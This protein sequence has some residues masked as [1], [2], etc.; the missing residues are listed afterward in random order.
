MAGRD[1]LVSIVMP[2]HNGA[3]WLDEALA[4]VLAQTMGDFELVAVD[5]GSTD[6]TPGMLAAYAARD[7][8][9]RVLT[10]TSSQ[11]AGPARNSGLSAARGEYLL[12][13][14]ADDAFEPTL[15]ER[16][17]AAAQAAQADMV[18]FGADEL[19][20][21]RRRKNRF[22]FVEE[23]L[24][25]RDPFNRDDVPTRLFQ[26]CTPEAWSKL[27][28]RDFVEEQ[29]LR[30]QDL[31]NTNDMLFTMSAL[32]L[33]RRVTSVREVLVHHRVGRRGSIQS[34][35]GRSL[36]FLDALRA[37][38]ARL[39][40][41]GLL[42]QLQESFANLAVFHCLFNDKAPAPWPHVFAE[43]GVNQLASDAYWLEGDF[44]RVAGLI[45]GSWDEATSP[46]EAYGAEFWRSAAL[47]EHAEML[48]RE[49]EHEEDME[50]AWDEAELV[51]ASTSFRLGH[52]L[53]APMRLLGKGRS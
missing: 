45:C 48:R 42:P 39:D 34:S 16:T 35:R 31:K 19:A 10:H 51:K 32:A 4:G 52:A 9:V 15:L 11:G 20:P 53:T 13:L 49:R 18:L 6:A 33:A 27:I 41:E 40:S 28:R 17:M 38:Q 29:G 24:P 43:F 44:L 47:A 46:A 50:R 14:D 8:R 3:P 5:D 12:F 2:V 37:L 1:P 36:V 25:A 22:I 26:L 23:L 7:T 21:A 30:F